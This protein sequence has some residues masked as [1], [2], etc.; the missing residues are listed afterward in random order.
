MKPFLTIDETSIDPNSK[1]ADRDGYDLREAARA[2][3]ID[4]EGAVALL[5]V[6]GK[7]Y[8]KLPG[9][10]IEGDESVEDALARELKEELGCSADIITGLGS[11]QEYRYFWNMNQLSYCYLAKVTGEKGIPQFTAEEKANGFEVAWV[12]SLDEAIQL[13]R[14]NGESAD[15]GIAFMRMRDI[16]IVEKAKLYI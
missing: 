8:Y 15:L 13:L 1:T 5:Y 9:G 12:A 14:G 16:A 11:I 4:D 3:V 10:G 7:N 6:R 2:V